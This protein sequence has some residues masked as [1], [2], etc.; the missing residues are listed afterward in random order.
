[1][2]FI[3]LIVGLLLAALWEDIRTVHEDDWFFRFSDWVEKLVLPE[4]LTV[5]VVVL[6]PAFVVAT[7]LSSLDSFLFGLGWLA[8]AIFLLLYSLGR[9]DFEGQARVYGGSVASGD[10][11]GAWLHLREWL[12]LE[13][14]SA[15][16]DARALQTLAIK[17]IGYEGFQRQ[18]AVLFWFVVLGPAGA[19]A[20]RLLQLY[21]GDKGGETSA[22]ILFVI[23]WV[24][25]RLYALGFALTG[26]FLGSVDELGEAWADP[27]MDAPVV[28]SRVGQAALRL[29]LED[30]A[31]Q[32]ED[33]DCGG[34]G[35]DVEALCA[36]LSRSWMTWLAIWSIVVLLG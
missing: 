19:L 16:A 27:G 13:E 32:S 6:A 12:G 36:L 9:G 4:P 10:N 26:D 29:P 21:H 17:R 28:I 25:C 30:S 1:M 18:F 20:Y 23:D 11:E 34:Y 31:A 5:A 15:P 35:N 8:A 33:I 24:P 3:A 2:T 14:D 22:K 7:L